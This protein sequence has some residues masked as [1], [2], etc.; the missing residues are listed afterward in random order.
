MTSANFHDLLSAIVSNSLVV[1][2]SADRTT[3][4][5]F[6]SA[7]SKSLPTS[8][9]GCSAPRWAKDTVLLDAMTDVS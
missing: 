3:F 8:G 2:K 4:V 1:V 9:L 6:F 5:F 7:I